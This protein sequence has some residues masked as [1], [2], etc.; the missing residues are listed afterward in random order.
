MNNSQRTRD[1]ARGIYFWACL[2][3]MPLDNKSSIEYKAW[4]Q[5]ENDHTKREIDFVQRQQFELFDIC[6]GWNWNK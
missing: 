2:Q 3:D 5:W 6:N 4:K 1:M